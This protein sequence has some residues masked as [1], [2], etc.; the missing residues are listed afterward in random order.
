MKK[1]AV[2]LIKL[3]QLTL[4]PFLGGGKCR[5]YPNCSQYVLESVDKHGFIYGVVL[6][7][8]RI[9][10]CA[11]WSKGGYDPVPDRFRFGI[12]YR[13]NKLLGRTSKG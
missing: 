11:P 10:R 3:Y 12:G 4:S 13:L 8:S 2:L 9:C 7:V 1:I 6:G 5:F